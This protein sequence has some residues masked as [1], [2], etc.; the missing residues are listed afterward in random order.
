[1]VGCACG[2]PAQQS[3]FL[4]FVPWAISHGHNPFF[5]NYVDFPRGINLAAST[6]MPLLGVIF[7]PLTIFLG[8]TST[9]SFLMWLAFPL[10]AISAGFVARQL[11]KSNIGSG[12]AGLLYGFSPYEFHEAFGH[13]NLL[14]VPLPPLIIYVSYNLLIRQSGRPERWGLLLGALISGQFL[15][16]SE[17]AATTT[18]VVAIGA[19][20]WTSVNWRLVNVQR[21]QYILRSLF[22]ALALSFIILC[23][24]I[25]YQLFGRERII[26]PAQGGI[27]NPYRTNLW[28]AVYPTSQTLFGPTSLKTVADHFTN[29]DVSEN[30]SYLGIPLIATFIAFGAYYFRSG[31]V[32]LVGFLAVTCWILS[33]GPWLAV[34]LHTTSLRLPFWFLTQLPL[35]NNILPN[36]LSLYVMFFVSLTLAIGLGNVVEDYLQNHGGGNAPSRYS[37]LVACCFGLLVLA[38]I[39]SLFPVLPIPTQSTI[40]TVPKFFSSASAGD[41]SDGSVLLTYPYI[42]P[43]DDQA[44]LWQLSSGFKWRVMGGYFVVPFP[45]SGSVYD[46]PWPTPPQQVTNYLVYWEFRDDPRIKRPNVPAPTLDRALI[47]DTRLFVRHYQIGGVVVSLLAPNAN[48]AI[49]L[50]TNA[51][52]RPRKQGGA[53]VWLHIV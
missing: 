29:G 33:L 15:I 10:S 28:G 31:W 44:L 35:L 30:G 46:G 13:L 52:G 20:V 40:Q 18:V 6:F 5:T 48:R 7:Y 37:R 16:S 34:G 26:A 8:A 39:V 1:M 50:F 2:D 11:T 4:G 43:N 14:F 36:R 42:Y 21:L 17:I 25:W 22:S 23:V 47:D 3:W 27:G 24:P 9:Y 19:T 12:I 49:A 41:I 32:R 45:K 38:S 51:F 53:D